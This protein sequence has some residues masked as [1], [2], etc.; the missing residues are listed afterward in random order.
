MLTLAEYLKGKRVSELQEFHSFW[1]RRTYSARTASISGSL[2]IS[3]SV[4]FFR[5]ERRMASLT[6][7]TV[8]ELEQV[9]QATLSAAGLG[10]VQVF[11]DYDRT[12]FGQHKAIT[13]DVERA[14][15]GG[16]VA[17]AT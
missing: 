15:G 9:H 14:A 6:A 1:A 17:V 3:N 12:T 10:K 13:I 5:R 2:S 4:F 8:C 16:W 7:R 11:Q